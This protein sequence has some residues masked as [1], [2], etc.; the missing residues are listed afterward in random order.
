MRILFAGTPANAAATLVALHAA[1][2]E[3][4]CVLTR[5]DA[6]IGRK[7]ISTPSAVAQAADSLGIP[8]VK[9]AKVIAETLEELGRFTPDLGVVVAY[10]SLLKRQAL[11]F[12]PKGWINVHYSLLPKWRGASPV[13]SALL[14]GETE[15][16]VS[17]FQL[18]EGMDTGPVHLSVPTTIEPGETSGRL[19][20]RLTQL[21]ISALN[22]LLPRIEA[23]L[24]KP[25]TQ[26]AELIKKLPTATKISRA[27]AEID[28]T[29]S[30]VQIEN[31]IRAMNPEPM[32]WTLLAD[33]S[34]RIINARSSQ[35][36]VDLASGIEG[37]VHQIDKRIYVTCGQNTMLE[38]LEVQP[39]GKNPM[40]AADWARGIIKDSKV[41]FTN[42][43]K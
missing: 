37:Q 1:G 5:P 26:D 42:G 33:Q 35:Q 41:V 34:F 13:Q 43:S 11:D 9:A 16:G 36:T 32:A 38:L 2:H 7:K 20:D 21:G 14:N 19:I 24:A 18:D 23:G 29:K 30:A 40:N 27:T 31:L 6:L 12:L 39:A 15:T 22:E 8:T 3:I 17:V 25:R 10:G 28:W 4:V